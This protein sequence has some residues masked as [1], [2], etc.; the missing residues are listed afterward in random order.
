MADMIR[1]AMTPGPYRR[2]L[3]NYVWDEANGFATDVD[4]ATAAE[5]LTYPGGGYRLGARPKPA[6]GKELATLMGVE[7]KNLVL[8]DE[9]E[10][11]AAPERTVADVTGGQWTAQLAEH[12]IHKLEQLGALDDAG[13]DNLAAAAGAS[14]DEVKAWV[15]QAKQ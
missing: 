1:I 10:V 2:E 12:G 6:A 9:G 14:R 5:L 4:I 15:R 11:T 3:N 13:I 7:P 8:P